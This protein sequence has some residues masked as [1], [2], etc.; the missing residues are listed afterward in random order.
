M[1]MNG[2]CRPEVCEN[3]LL[4]NDEER[5]FK[6]LLDVINHFGLSTQ[7]RAAG[8]WVRD[9]LLGRTSSDIDIALDDML[10]KQFAEK[11]NEYLAEMGMETHGIGVITRWGVIAV[12]TV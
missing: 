3:F 6:T 7:P 12:I 5:I 2:A 9:K 4:T 11:V 1:Q 8:G 10:G